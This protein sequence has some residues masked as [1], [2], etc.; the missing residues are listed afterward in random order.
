MGAERKEAER[1]E[2][3][4]FRRENARRSG[5]I[6]EAELQAAEIMLIA[7]GFDK[8]LAAISQRKTL[9]SRV[10]VRTRAVNTSNGE[11]NATSSLT[12]LDRGSEPVKRAHTPGVSLLSAQVQ[13]VVVGPIVPSIVDYASETD[14]ESS[15]RSADACTE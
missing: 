5:E 3:K 15:S 14:S 7:S 4:L 6:D 2:M 1:Q 13:P 10:T 11:A 9:P 8:R 12:D